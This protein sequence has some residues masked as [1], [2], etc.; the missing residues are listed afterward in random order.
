MVK[1]LCVCVFGLVALACDSTSES[2]GFMDI[3]CMKKVEISFPESWH[4][5]PKSR[6]LSK[7]FITT[8]Y[9][10]DSTHNGAVSTEVNWISVSQIFA[11]VGPN[12]FTQLDPNYRELTVLTICGQHADN[13]ETKSCHQSCLWFWLCMYSRWSF[14]RP[15]NTWSP[16]ISRQQY[17]PLYHDVNH[18]SRS[19]FDFCPP[20]RPEHRRSQTR[21]NSSVKK[22]ALDVSWCLSSYKIRVFEILVL[23]YGDVSKAEFL[24]LEF[25]V[26]GFLSSAG[27]IHSIVTNRIGNERSLCKR[28]LTYAFSTS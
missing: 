12:L 13:Y 6:T 26:S 5:R 24:A 9:T 10:V 8:Y 14:S 19:M 7:R 2:L 17:S 25:P 1:Y 23:P 18:E 22:A 20:D 3:V 4:V 16:S 11:L 21:D 28:I 15:D 27:E